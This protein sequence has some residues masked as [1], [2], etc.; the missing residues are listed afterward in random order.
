M[1][2]YLS[3]IA[4]LLLVWLNQD[5]PN[6]KNISIF[7]CV[8]LYLTVSMHNGKMHCD[9]WDYMN[10]FTGH[11][12]S[13][14]GSVD[15]PNG[16]EPGYVFYVK[17]LRLLFSTNTSY[18]L[19][20][21]LTICIPFFLMCYQKSNDIL[22]SILLLMVVNNGY[23][24]F[25]FFC[26]QRQMLSICLLLVAL[27]FYEER[28]KYWYYIVP[29]LFVASFFTHSTATFVLPLFFILLFLRINNKKIYYW[30]AGVTFILALTVDF[31]ALFQSLSYILALYLEGN[32]SILQFDTVYDYGSVFQYLPLTLLFMSFVYYTDDKEVNSI[33][34]KSFFLSVLLK[35]MFGFFPHITR[36]TMFFLLLAIIGS[37]PQIND[38]NN[39]KKSKLYFMLAIIQFIILEYRALDKFDVNTIFY[40]LPY[41]FIWE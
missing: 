41:N 38:S 16:I 23:L 14:Y 20:W 26:A 19:L 13:M 39:Y 12:E 31:S 21:G 35:N 15:D 29:T 10:F 7:A 3:V 1:Y 11:G 33:Y 18:I 9:Y 27:W 28:H 32:R 37:I 6:K 40:C 4:I 25:M 8:L 17:A 5:Y 34:L 2:V 30:G 24:F 22:L 36:M